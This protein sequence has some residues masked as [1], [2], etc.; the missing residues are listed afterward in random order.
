MHR[1]SHHRDP[2]EPRR[3]AVVLELG[4]GIGAL[5]V[6]TDPDL[7]GAEV[8]ISAGDDDARRTHQEV[9]RRRVGVHETCALVFDNLREGR[10][11]LWVDD[12]ARTRDVRVESGTVT[13]LDWRGPRAGAGHASHDGA[14]D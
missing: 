1:H 2:R 4:D 13:E 14:R 11:T 9:L 3:E 8:E 7:V 6:Q 12:V 5:V 10:Y